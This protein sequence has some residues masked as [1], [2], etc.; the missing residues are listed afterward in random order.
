[1]KPHPR[2][3]PSPDQ[4]HNTVAV[5]HHNHSTHRHRRW[6]ISAAPP[7]LDREDEEILRFARIW[8]PYG[9]APADETFH[10]FG[11]STSRF[12]DKLWE[13]LRGRG[14]RRYAADQLAAAFPPP[15]AQ[16]GSNR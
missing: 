16:V 7:S 12:V 2:Q 1:M 10:H 13:I 15:I 11:M 3:H 6:P 8:A 4:P 5:S 9:G 14:R